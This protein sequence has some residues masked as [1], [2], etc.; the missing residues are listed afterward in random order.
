M[1]SFLEFPDAV[2]GDGIKYD[3]KVYA[4]QGLE[5]QSIK[6]MTYRDT[7]QWLIQFLIHFSVMTE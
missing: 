5:A 1:A 7:K 6:M 2:T 4:I 3:W